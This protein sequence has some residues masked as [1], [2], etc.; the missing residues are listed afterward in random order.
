MEVGGGER[1]R[2]KQEARGAAKPHPPQSCLNS[3]TL[4]GLVPTRTFSPHGEGGP[5]PKPSGVEAR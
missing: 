4:A 3:T 2:A 1:E 5:F